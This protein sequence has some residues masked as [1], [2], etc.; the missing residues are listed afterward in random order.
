MAIRSCFVDTLSGFNIPPCFPI[1]ILYNDA[2]LSS[3]GSARTAFPGVISTT[4]ALRLPAPNTESLIDS[5]LRPNPRLLVRSPMAKTAKGAWS[6]SSARCRQLTDWSNTGPPRFLENPSRTF[7]LLS[8]PGRSGWPY[9]DG[10][11]S[12]APIVWKM[13]APALIQSRGSIT[14]LQYSLSTLQVMRYRI[15]MQD[16]VPAAG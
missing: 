15:R 2:P 6:R 11:L 13:K 9:L 1:T 7:A 5:L 8:D 12:A 4:R 14:R 10:Q 3:T 16:S